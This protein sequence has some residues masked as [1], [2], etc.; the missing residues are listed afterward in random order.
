MLSHD[1]LLQISPS[2][3][4]WEWLAGALPRRLLSAFCAEVPAF[5]LKV[6]LGQLNPRKLP[7]SDKGALITAS[8]LFGES[9]I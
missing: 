1:R 4:T 9:P 6:L 8:E 7:S 5:I 2:V 3:K